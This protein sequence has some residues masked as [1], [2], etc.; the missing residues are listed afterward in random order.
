M[1]EEE[2]VEEEV[3]GNKSPEFITSPTLHDDDEDDRP[4]SPD[5]SP[6]ITD[7]EGDE[8]QRRNKKAKTDSTTGVHI[9]SSPSSQQVWSPS[10]NYSSSLSSYVSNTDNEEEE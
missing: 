5:Y 6:F 9:Y 10:S 1:E 7:D 8:K 3:T 4:C 2:E